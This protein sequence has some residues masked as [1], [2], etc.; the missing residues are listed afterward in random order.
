MSETPVSVRKL[1]TAIPGPK[2][3][4]LHAHRLTQVSAGVGAALPVYIDHAHG[5]IV[6]DVDVRA[7]SERAKALLRLASTQVD[8]IH[9]PGR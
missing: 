4:A 8:D 7:M 3:Q 2:S 1:V 9:E 5:A 6:T